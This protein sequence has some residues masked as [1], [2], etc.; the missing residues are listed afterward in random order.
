[1]ERAKTEILAMHCA[2]LEGRGRNKTDIFFTCENQASLTA[3][4]AHSTLE[5]T[6]IVPDL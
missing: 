6:I 4:V 5:E 3:P 1:M 2:M